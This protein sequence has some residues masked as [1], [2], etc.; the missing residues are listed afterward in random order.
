[1][2]WLTRPLVTAEMLRQ[3]VYWGVVIWL[4]AI[5]TALVHKLL[6]A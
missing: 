1:M 4:I 5:L 6:L 3:S 2:N